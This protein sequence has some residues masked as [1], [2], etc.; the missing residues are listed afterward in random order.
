MQV[1]DFKVLEGNAATAL[2]KPGS[3]V[4][5]EDVA[6]KYFG[7]E[8]AIGKTL[9]M[10]ENRKPSIVTAVLN[11]RQSCHLSVTQLFHKY[12]GLH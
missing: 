3:I 10:G 11:P 1:F 4:I 6:K 5:T 7:N 12:T 2:M 9:L 8:R